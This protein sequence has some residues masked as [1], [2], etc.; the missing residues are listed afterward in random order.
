MVRRKKVEKRFH[1]R[2]AGSS[3]Q[4]T[5]LTSEEEDSTRHTG[6]A[7]EWDYESTRS[8]DGKGQAPTST[9][10]KEQGSVAAA[11]EVRYTPPPRPRLYASAAP[12]PVS[13]RN[14]HLQLAGHLYEMEMEQALNGCL[15]KLSPVAEQY[16]IVSASPPVSVALPTINSSSINSSLNDT[17]SEA[18]SPPSHSSVVSRQTYICP[19]KIARCA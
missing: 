17:S 18:S 14:Y 13:K 3:L 8:S 12:P 6:E 7:D 9:G 10:D 2:D 11:S 16:Y 15:E 1:P 19:G 5:E 4:R